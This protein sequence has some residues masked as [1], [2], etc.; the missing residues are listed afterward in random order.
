[1]KKYLIPVIAVLVLLCAV[2]SACSGGTDEPMSST[3]STS[4]SRVD[5]T[6]NLSEQVSEMLSSDN[7]SGMTSNASEMPS[8]TNENTSSTDRATDAMSTDPAENTS[9]AVG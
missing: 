2:L 5:Q 6:N 3:S 4:E 8:D 9:A 1:M 7:A